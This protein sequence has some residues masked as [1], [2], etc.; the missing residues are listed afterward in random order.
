MADSFDW[1][2]IDFLER[3]DEEVEGHASFAKYMSNVLRGIRYY[4]SSS[5]WWVPISDHE[6]MNISEKVPTAW[7]I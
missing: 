5:E 6:D 2:D 7:R 3:I 4:S 1:V